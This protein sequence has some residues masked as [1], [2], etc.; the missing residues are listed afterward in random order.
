MLLFLCLFETVPAQDQNIIN[1]APLLSREEEKIWEPWKGCQLLLP[2]TPSL[3]AHS[4]LSWQGSTKFMRVLKAHCPL[5]SSPASLK[6]KGHS[7]SFSTSCLSQLANTH[8]TFQ[9]WLRCPETQVTA[10]SLG[11]AKNGGEVAGNIKQ[12]VHLPAL[13][14]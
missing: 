14:V 8:S 3:L 11:T 10:L 2:W 7:S 9:P 13:V 5:P 6:L 1:W 12:P 4:V